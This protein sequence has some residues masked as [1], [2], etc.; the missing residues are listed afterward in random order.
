MSYTPTSEIIARANTAAAAM[1]VLIDVKTNKLTSDLAA[2]VSTALSDKTITGGQIQ[3]MLAAAQAALADIAKL[4][5]D[6]DALRV[7]VDALK[8][9]PPP[10]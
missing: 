5:V 3:Q 10:P 8:V 6:V 2:A 9:P 1:K 4:R 7:D